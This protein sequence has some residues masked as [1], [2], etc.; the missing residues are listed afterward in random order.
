[1]NA[2]KIGQAST[3][4]NRVT[5]T[6]RSPFMQAYQRAALRLGVELAR[7]VGGRA[8]KALSFREERAGGFPPDDTTDHPA[9]RVSRTIAAACSSTKRG[10]SGID[11]AARE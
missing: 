8:G 4:Q 10:A 1:M 7:F 6:C 9:C 3:Y 5:R 11:L 2:E